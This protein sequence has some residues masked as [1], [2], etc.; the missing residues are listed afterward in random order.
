MPPAGPADESQMTAALGADSPESVLGGACAGLVAANV[1]I[2]KAARQVGGLPKGE[3]DKL[4]K[5]FMQQ[6]RVE[7]D[8]TDEDRAQDMVGQL[9]E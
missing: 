1:S 6:G 9:R 7:E 2:S 4:Y 5:L 3:Y 8:M